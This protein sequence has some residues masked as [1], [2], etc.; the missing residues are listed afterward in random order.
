VCLVH[1]NFLCFCP[2]AEIDEQRRWFRRW[3]SSVI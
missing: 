3:M 1:L 2:C